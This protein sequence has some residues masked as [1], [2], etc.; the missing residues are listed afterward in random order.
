MPE[1]QLFGAGHI[2]VLCILTVIS[3][4]IIRCRLRLTGPVDAVIRYLIAISLF[5][6][7]AVG[8][9]A[10]YRV[11]VVVIPLNFCDLA[12]FASILALLTLKPW[13]CHI[14]YVWGLAGTL[15]ALLQ[16]DLSKPFPDFWWFHFFLLHGGVVLSAVYLGATQRIQ[17][18]WRTV[19]WLI[20]VTNFYVAIV[21]AINWIYG[22]NFGYLAQK[23]A[24]PSILD[25]L[26]EWPYYLLSMEIIGIV[27]MIILFLPFSYFRK[28]LRV[29]RLI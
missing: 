16:P 29:D 27:S 21:V 2:T 26:G 8:M 14:C 6:I 3:V 25:Y 19:G 15:Q 5:L 11:G 17:P 20:V 7:G 23:P 13:L 4:L 28:Q 18:S 1:F 22:T 12:L 10:A 24:R 9:I